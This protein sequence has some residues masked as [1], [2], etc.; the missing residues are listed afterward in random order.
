LAGVVSGGV[1]GVAE[2]FL[3]EHYG[4]DGFSGGSGEDKALYWTFV[5]LVTIIASVI[6]IVYLY[7]DML[8]TTI[9]I[10]RVR[11]NLHSSTKQMPGLFYH[12][13]LKQSHQNDVVHAF[14]QQWC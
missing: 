5:L 4:T 7:Y 12:H 13:P 9:R 1:S 3:S 14:Q 11:E 10:S 2:Y 6:E 8:K